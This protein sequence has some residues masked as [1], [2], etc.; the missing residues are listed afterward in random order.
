ML[1]QKLF[2]EIMAPASYFSWSFLIKLL[3]HD[4]RCVTGLEGPPPPRIAD[5]EKS[6]GEDQ[7]LFPPK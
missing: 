4:K 1:L 2:L 6:R 7:L 5:G 3:T